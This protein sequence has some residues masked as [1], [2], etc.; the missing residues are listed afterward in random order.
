[1]R[2]RQPFRCRSRPLPLH[3]ILKQR[4]PRVISKS[5]DPVCKGIGTF[6]AIAILSQPS[7]VNGAL[8]RTGSCPS[9]NASSTPSP[10][11]PNKV[12]PLECFAKSRPIPVGAG[13]CPR[14]ERASRPR[15]ALGSCFSTSPVLRPTRGF[16]SLLV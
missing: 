14:G 8:L 13:S 11:A 7:K 6:L 3:R 2:L 9:A 4:H 15:S 16:D 1:M 5:L 12:C 10:I